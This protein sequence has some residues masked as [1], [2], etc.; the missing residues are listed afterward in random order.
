MRPAGTQHTGKTIE[1]AAVAAREIEIDTS[2]RY[3]DVLA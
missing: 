2:A 3:I 1:V